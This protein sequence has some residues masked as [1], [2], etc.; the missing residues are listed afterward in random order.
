MC[1]CVCACVCVFACADRGGNG[2]YCFCGM[3]T[4]SRHI[5]VFLLILKHVFIFWFIDWQ[6]LETY[7]RSLKLTVSFLGQEHVDVAKTL[8]NL[9][10]E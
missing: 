6:A 4:F 1:V 2:L 3:P 7:Q 5:F 10:S 9:V 8:N